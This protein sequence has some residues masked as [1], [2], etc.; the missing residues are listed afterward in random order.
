MANFVLVHGAWHGGWCWKKLTPLL[1]AAGHQVYTPTLTGLGE[2]AH[3][4]SRA[5]NLDTFVQDVLAVM[6]FEEL[7]DVVLVG[8]SAAGIFL[9]ILVERALP[10]LR[11]VVYLDAASAPSGQAL[12]DRYPQT[13]EAFAGLIATA[14]EGWRVPVP[15]TTFGVTDPDDIRW[16]QSH[17]TPHPLAA[18]EQPALYAQDP[19][20]LVPHTYIACIGDNPPGGAKF[21]EGEGMAYL[22]LATGHDAMITAPQALA[23][24]L[25]SL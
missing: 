3:L 25:V 22:E 12:F 13:R 7:Q 23:K 10:R 16:L 21:P 4:L 5:V 20:P 14:G 1:R 18:S 2:R 8:H 15:D 19:R 9:P 11:H 24:I 17:L 6:E